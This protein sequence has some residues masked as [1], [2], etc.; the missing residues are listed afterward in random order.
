MMTI[1]LQRY[2]PL[3]LGV[4]ACVAATAADAA[5][6]DGLNPF[7]PLTAE[8]AV[9][10]VDDG[11][12]QLDAADGRRLTV[13]PWPKFLPQRFGPQTVTGTRQMHPA[14]P[15]DRLS[16]SHASE[17]SAWLELGSGARRS[18]ETVGNWKLQLSGG[19]W[20]VTDGKNKKPLE[21]K[22][23]Q[24]LPAMID[25]GTDRWCLYLL[26]STLPVAKP[27]IATETE[28]QIEWAAIRLSPL[29][30]RCPAAR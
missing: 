3:A 25:V 24:A 23:H 6:I 28:A 13:T 29:Q 7:A 14:G 20:I 2:I 12:M 4:A 1:R 5:R 19:R 26:S 17:P 16:F 9:P 11:T 30:K 8:R 18:A 27:D 21:T 22:D 10:T 15:I